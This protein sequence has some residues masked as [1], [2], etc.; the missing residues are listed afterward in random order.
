MNTPIKTEEYLEWFA[1][2]YNLMQRHFDGD[3]LFNIWYNMNGWQAGYGYIEDY[4]GFY[5]FKLL[6][7]TDNDFH[8]ALGK[9]YEHTRIFIAKLLVIESD[10]KSCKE[11]QEGV[12]YTTIRLLRTGEIIVTP[13]V[14]K[15]YVPSLLWNKETR[16][17]ARFEYEHGC[18]IYWP[19]QYK[20]IY[21]SIMQKMVEYL[22]G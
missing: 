20:F 10:L 19:E 11:F 4:E 2:N 18:L 5:F 22:N 8:K 6:Y 15:D 3:L 9:S 16:N 7:G 17:R 21:P 12:T 1:S 13:V 14:F